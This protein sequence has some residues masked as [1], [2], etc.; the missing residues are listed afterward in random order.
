[1]Q[2]VKFRRIHRFKVHPLRQDGKEDD[3]REKRRSTVELPEVIITF[4][5]QPF[6]KG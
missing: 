3:L 2:C 6:F 1:M 4:L 5:G